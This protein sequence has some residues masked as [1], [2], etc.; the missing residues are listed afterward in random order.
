MKRI[1]G[2]RLSR[3]LVSVVPLILAVLWLANCDGAQDADARKRRVQAL[4][5]YHERASLQKGWQRIATT[6]NDSRRKLL[7]KS[8]APS[9]TNGAIIALHGGGGTCSNYSSNIVLG[10]PMVKFGELAIEEGF[11]VFSLES[12]DGLVTDPKGHSAG[13]RWDCLARDDRPNIDLP[14]IEAVIT[15]VIPRLR[16]ENSAKDIFITGISNGGFMTILAATHYPDE[17]SAFAPV[18]AG[19]PYGTY[20]QCDIHVDTRPNAPGVFRD[21]E[22]NRLVSEPEAAKASKYGR[23]KKWPA[24]DD[25]GRPAFKQFHHQHDGVCDISCMEKAQRL[26]VQHG[27][28]TEGPFILKEPARRRIWNHFWMT[29]YNAPMIEFFKRHVTDKQP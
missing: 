10:K 22:T 12:T 11:A 8:P 1:R 28:K 4:Y 7:W 2:T 27:Y 14:F 18:S 17:I 29:E 26:L 9:W 3:T 19:D 16:P 23:E 25:Q 21:S 20:M 5:D 13:K 6:L 15:K 24:T